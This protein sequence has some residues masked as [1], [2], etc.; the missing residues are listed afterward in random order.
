MKSAGTI[1]PVILLDE[2]DKISSDMRGDPASALLEVLD[3]EQNNSFRDRYLEEP[4]D[5]SK[6]LFVTTA[7]TLDTIPAPLLD[8]M[9]VIELSGYTLEEKKEIARRYLIP[10]QL[11][12]N[13]LTEKD[14][15]FTDGAIKKIIEGYTMEAGVR[16]LER[17]IGAV[18]RKIAVTAADAEERVKVS[19]TE[20][21]AE[22][23]LGA[24]RFVK[25][26]V[27]KQPEVGAAVGLAWTA[28]GGV[29][30]T[31]EAAIVKGKGDVR[32][33]GKLG[34]VMKESALAA[35]TFIRS[36]A[37]RY[38]LNEEV[39]EES[40]V[41]IHVPEGATPK[42]GPSAGITM[43]TAVL[44]AFSGQPVK[45]SVAMTGEITLRGKV[46]PIGGLKEKALA[47]RRA[48][49]TRVI[50]PAENKKDLEEL[51]AP[52]R[53]EM[54]FIPVTDA[55]EVFGEAI[56]NFKICDAPAPKAE[57]RGRGGVYP[58]HGEPMP[59]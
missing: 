9:E 4:Y 37:S 11:K 34:D 52:I 6:V 10:K 1:N 25:N 40:D 41:H 54:T 57:K 38:G 20:K 48:G 42:D 33:T 21:A 7:N 43:A 46:L 2:I 15:S 17:T 13:G 47:A 29:T 56:E 53:A 59:C 8:R 51:P 16:T 26:E 32:L 35:L 30:L 39:F 12:A 18:C 14:A 31:V 27:E 36:H 23:Y 45:K 19:V 5:L 55:E 50:I 28:V 44:S 3:P 58:P 22:K 24:P 49:I